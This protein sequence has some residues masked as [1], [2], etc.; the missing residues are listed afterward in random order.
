MKAYQIRG[1]SSEIINLQR[2]AISVFCTNCAVRHFFSTRNICM[3]GYF[4]LQDTLIGIPGEFLVKVKW[5]ISRSEL[6]SVQY[7]FI[8]IIESVVPLGT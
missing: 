1:H 7:L 6:T 5:F 4:K 8:I 3:T 2:F